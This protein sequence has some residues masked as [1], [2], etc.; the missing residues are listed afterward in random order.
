VILSRCYRSIVA[1]DAASSADARVSP[2]VAAECTHIPSNRYGGYTARMNRRLALA[3]AAFA[4]L[5][6]LALSGCGNKGPLVLPD[7]PVD[8]AVPAETPAP[9]AAPATDATA[10]APPASGTPAR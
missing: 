8:A 2:A 4:I 5:L 10:P 3:S 9:E 6:P 1:I 7:K